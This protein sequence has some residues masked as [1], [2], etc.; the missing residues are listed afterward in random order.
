MRFRWVPIAGLRA[1]WIGCIGVIGDPL[2]PMAPMV[3]RSGAE[4][5]PPLTARATPSTTK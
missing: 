1:A 5:A 2:P 3:L 4:K